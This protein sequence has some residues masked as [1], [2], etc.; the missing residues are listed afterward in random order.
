MVRSRSFVKPQS[1]TGLNNNFRNSLRR[2]QHNNNEDI[3]SQSVDQSIISRL[4]PVYQPSPVLSRRN[5]EK[6]RSTSPRSTLRKFNS[7]A[8]LNDDVTP[9]GSPPAYRRSGSRDETGKN[10]FHR[11]VAGTTIGESD[12]PSKGKIHPYQGR[13]APKS[14][15]ICSNVAEGHTKAVLSVFAT[16]ELLFSA[17]KDRTVK[18][19]DICRKEEVDSLGGH[20]NNVVCVKYSQ[21]TRMAFTV[22]S[23]FIKVRYNCSHFRQLSSFSDISPLLSKNKISFYFLVFVRRFNID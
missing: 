10:V 7:A 8:K 5:L 1:N 18:V 16:D 21:A 9:P 2:Y 6:T 19:W 12:L 4:A 3:M 11:L 22:S 13:I 20:P 14:P 23:A 17:S 15:L